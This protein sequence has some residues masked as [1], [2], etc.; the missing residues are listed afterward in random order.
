MTNQKSLGVN[1]WN[2]LQTSV[3]IISLSSLM[4]TVSADLLKWR[5]GEWA[6]PQA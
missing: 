2:G 3:A 5:V 6:R 4:E 1:L